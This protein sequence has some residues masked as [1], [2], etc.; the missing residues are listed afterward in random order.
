MHA[1]QGQVELTILLVDP[2]CA[3]ISYQVVIIVGMAMIA[4]MHEG[5]H[6]YDYRA[7]LV[8]MDQMEISV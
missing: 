1:H 7:A 5:Y 8:H 6:G 2:G 4:G 3:F